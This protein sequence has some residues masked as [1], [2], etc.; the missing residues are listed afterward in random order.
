MLLL[1]EFPWNFLREISHFVEKKNMENHE[2]IILKT[3]YPC[4]TLKSTTHPALKD[5]EFRFREMYQPKSST[6]LPQKNLD[7]T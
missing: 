5:I 6:P 2:A 7:K 1:G 4:V 3:P